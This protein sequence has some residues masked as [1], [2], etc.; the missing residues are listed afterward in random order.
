MSQVP[1]AKKPKVTKETSAKLEKLLLLEEKKKLIQ[2]LPHLYGYKFYPWMRSFFE[3]T[4]KIQIVCA[5]NQI[6]KSSAQIRKI[7]HLATEPSLWKTLWPHIK[8]PRT[9]WYLYPSNYL[10]TV[11]FE[12]KWIPE[13]LPQGEF[14]KHPQYGWKADYRTR[15]VQAIHFNT[16]FSLYFKT[17]SQSPEDLQAGSAAVIGLDEEC[18]ELL[19]PELQARLLATD[20]Y[21]LSVFTPTLGQEFWREVVEERGVKERFKDAFKL[22]VSMYDC[23]LYEDGTPSFWTKE[24]IEKIKA[25]CKSEAEIQRRVYG[26][27]VLDSGLRYPGFNPS[28]NVIPS[29]PIPHDWPVY[30]GVDF[31]A[32]GKHNHPSAVTFLAVRPDFQL[33]YF[34]RGQRF[35]GIQ[36][37]AETLIEYVKHMRSDIPNPINGIFYD[38]SHSDLGIISASMGEPWT[39]AEKSH[40]IGEQVLNVGFKNSMLFIFNT[41]ELQ[42]LSTELKLLKLSTAKNMAKDD[43]VDSARYASSKVPFDWGIIGDKPAVEVPKVLTEQ[44]ERRKMFED[45][46]GDEYFNNVENELEAWDS[47]MNPYD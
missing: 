40:L 41:P 22:Q 42:T 32:G 11:E 33:G 38:Y 45:E 14:K 17:Y 20:G 37:T 26:R 44:E 28:I 27:F 8:H 18:D 5:S 23:I 9:G 39:L 30:I 24:R 47:L 29:R 34:F 3:S 6:G 12:K 19:I 16:G 35:D 21:L 1:P 4:N 25:A 46:Y 13:F 36:M 15:Y 10:A 43:H 7:I 31:G 2:G